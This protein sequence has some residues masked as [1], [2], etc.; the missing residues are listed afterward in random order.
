MTISGVLK[1]IQIELVGRFAQD[2][3]FGVLKNIQI[4]LV[5]RWSRE[6]QRNVIKS[7]RD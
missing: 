5:G 6:Q 1:N 7:R 2:D 4:E 3:D